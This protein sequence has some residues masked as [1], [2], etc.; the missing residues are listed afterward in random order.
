VGVRVVPTVQLVGKVEDFRRAQISVQQRNRA[1]S[2]GVNWY[3]VTSAV[4]L[5]ALY[6]SRKIGDPGVRKG[7][8]QTQLQVRF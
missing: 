4:R 3:A 6:V 8:L 2:A 1:W 5:S 7:A